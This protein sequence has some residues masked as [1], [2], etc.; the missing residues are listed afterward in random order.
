MKKKIVIFGA[1]GY[2]GAYL[3]D[4]CRRHLPE[5]FEVLAVGRKNLGFYKNEGI[6]T[7][8]VDVCREE[9]FSDLPTDDI[10]A[11]INLTGLLPAYLKKYDPFAYI[12]TNIKGS[13]RI[14]EYARKVQADRVLY[15]QTWAEQAGYWG[16][17]AVLSP[18]LP[19]KLLYTGDHAFYSITK[20]MIVDTMEYYKQEYGVL[21]KFS[22]VSSDELTDFCRGSEDVE[23]IN[24]ICAR[25]ATICEV[26]GIRLEDSC[27]GI[28]GFINAQEKEK[29]EFWRRIEA[30][31]QDG[32]IL[33]KRSEDRKDFAS[34][35]ANEN[36]EIVSKSAYENNREYKVLND[37]N[38]LIRY[39]MQ[40]KDTQ[41]EQYLWD[42]FDLYSSMIDVYEQLLLSK[43]RSNSRKGVRFDDYSFRD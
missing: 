1:T 36:P 12:E 13:L 34:Q 30:V 10:Y 24:S 31:A 39:A 17:T 20:C 41:S 25:V 28:I 14:M 22:S 8:K 2:I 27:E 6:R 35:I 7:V 29:R 15:T 23:Q 4:Y 19:R 32:A 9:D 11:V 3:T 40:E 33:E 38:F 26:M 42:G 37:I 5:D 18:D 43:G 21:K 16:K